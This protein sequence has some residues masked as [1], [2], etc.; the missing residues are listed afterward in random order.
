VE[1]DWRDASGADQLLFSVL[2]G[3]SDNRFLIYKLGS[4]AEL[5]MFAQANGGSAEVNQGVSSSGFSGIQKIA[6]AYADADFE[7]YRNGSS[8]SSDTVGSLSALATLTDIDLG[9]GATGSNQANMHIRAV[10]LFT[11]RLSDAECQALTTL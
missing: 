6:F 9:Q 7:L 5:R 8:I 2:D 3:T 4:P 1:V 10:A 11:R